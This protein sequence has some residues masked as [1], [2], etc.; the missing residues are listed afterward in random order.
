M[1]HNPV[2]VVVLDLLSRITFATS[3]WKPFSASLAVSALRPSP[4]AMRTSTTPRACRSL[5]FAMPPS[6]A[7][8]LGSGYPWMD[9]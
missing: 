9:W 1:E 2:V 4:V 8:P 7:V 6:L 3:S 5:A